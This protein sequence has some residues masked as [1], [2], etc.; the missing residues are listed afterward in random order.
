[1]TKTTPHRKYQTEF[2]LSIYS[3]EPAILAPSDLDKINANPKEIQ[4]KLRGSNIYLILKRP[5]I[6]FEPESL[7][8]VDREV[9]GTLGIQLEEGVI[10]KPF[11][12]TGRL[13]DKVGSVKA[14]KYPYTKLTL[15]DASGNE[16]PTIPFTFFMPQIEAALDGHDHMEVAYVGQAFGAAG[17]RSAVDRLSSHSTLQKILADI[18][19]KQ[20]NMEVFLALYQ[21]EYDRFIISMDGINKARITGDPDKMHYQKMLDAD[22]TRAMRISLA[23]AALIRYFQPEYNKEY[24]NEFPKKRHKILKKLYDYDFAALTVEA[25]VEDLGLHLYSETIRSNWHHIA[26]F[27]IHDPVERKSF[28]FGMP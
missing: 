15:F 16:G 1:M 19:A 14:S 20:P 25:S 21:F 11:K 18:A 12:F 7:S 3:S 17:E 10:K 26:N 8:I 24:K 27:D 28:F 9:C 2:A 6:S 23:E 22:F 13:P 5:R 4:E